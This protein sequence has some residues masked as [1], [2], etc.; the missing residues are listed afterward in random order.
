MLKRQVNAR[1][2]K[3]NHINRVLHTFIACN[4]AL[5]RSTDE[6]GLRHAVCRI[7]RDIG[8]YRLAWIGLI[9]TDT[10]DATP[11]YNFV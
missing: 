7:L 10:A 5:A 4:Q 8:G 11:S 3:L 9:D 6:S 2:R 1:T